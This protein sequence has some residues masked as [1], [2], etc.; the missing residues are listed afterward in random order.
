VRQG[1]DLPTT[2]G[3]WAAHWH[4]SGALIA[5]RLDL[6][7][8]LGSLSF[9]LTFV[10]ILLDWAGYAVARTA[11]ATPEALRMMRSMVSHSAGAVSHGAKNGLLKTKG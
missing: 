6:G 3:R 10:V 4:Q 11:L 9:S 5:Q 7:T 1:W 8:A 2:L